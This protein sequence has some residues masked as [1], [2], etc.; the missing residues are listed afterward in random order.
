MKKCHRLLQIKAES[1]VEPGTS[2]QGSRRKL[3][4]GHLAGQLISWDCLGNVRFANGLLTIGSGVI[5]VV[6]DIVVGLRMLRGQVF[7]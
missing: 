6:V 1:P 7:T 4:S 5:V 3:V 2:R